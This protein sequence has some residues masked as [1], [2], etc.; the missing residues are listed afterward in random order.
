MARADRN[1][2]FS[3]CSFFA[4]QLSQDFTA[5][6][7]SVTLYSCCFLRCF[8]INNFKDR[9]V[10]VCVCVCM[11]VYTVILYMEVLTWVSY[12][13][14]PNIVN[15]EKSGNSK[16][17]KTTWNIPSVV[18]TSLF[19]PFCVNVCPGIPV[20]HTRNSHLVLVTHLPTNEH[21]LDK[22]EGLEKLATVFLPLK[23]HLKTLKLHAH[24]ELWG[25]SE[26]VWC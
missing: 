10:C 8:R 3:Q 15:I 22:A 19:P 13:Y 18:L 20:S 16:A 9:K 5:A 24:V 23:L 2:D 26:K 25:H 7:I 11:Y 4:C 6:G 1:M 17:K 12:V 21:L 14:K